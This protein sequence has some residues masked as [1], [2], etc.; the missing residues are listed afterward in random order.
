MRWITTAGAHLDSDDIEQELR[1]MFARNV[2]EPLPDLD[3]F[4]GYR[5]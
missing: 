4:R 3:F 2:D 5:V 1:D